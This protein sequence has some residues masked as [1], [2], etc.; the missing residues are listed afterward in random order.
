MILLFSGTYP[1]PPAFPVGVCR[2]LARPQ[3]QGRKGGAHSDWSIQ[4]LPWTS[5]LTKFLLPKSRGT[6]RPHVTG[7]ISLSK[8]S[9]GFSGPSA[10]VCC[11]AVHSHYR[12]CCDSFLQSFCGLPRSEVFG[13]SAVADPCTLQEKQPFAPTYSSVTGRLRA[14][15]RD[16]VEIDWSW[17][18]LE[19]V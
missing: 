2:A 7:S 1:D 3:G 18:L 9:S 14:A 4:A 6:T 8:G 17:E 13:G 5:Y 12:T 11:A 16:M 10:G 19:Q 15:E